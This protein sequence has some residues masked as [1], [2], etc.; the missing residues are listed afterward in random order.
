MP[1]VGT[2][3]AEISALYRLTPFQV[4]GISTQQFAP[5]KHGL[6]VPVV[7][8]RIDCGGRFLRD[9]GTKGVTQ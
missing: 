3:A 4:P 5:G 1:I 7:L 8:S 2:F 9:A 6:L